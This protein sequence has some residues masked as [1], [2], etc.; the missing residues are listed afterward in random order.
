MGNELKCT[1][2]FGKETSEGKALLE[3][4]EILFRGD[5]RLKIPFASIK[6]A[7]AVDGELHLQTANG[8]A[9]FEL[10][11]AAEK[12]REK[13]LHPKSRI[14]K[15]GVKAGARVSM[16]GNFEAELFEEL[17]DLETIVTK[18]KVAADSDAVF[19][20]ADS[21]KE[22]SQVAKIAKSVKG[23]AAL[24]IVY[25][26]GQKGITENDVIAAGRKTGLKDVKVVGFSS[27]HTALKFVIPLDKR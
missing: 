14:E 15:L 12:W 7:K 22:L 25:P 1:V 8:L 5:F 9:V 16:V 27:T 21:Q 6:S 18:D 11:P 19:F 23:A 4:S 20:A 10:G 3:T 2:R 13:I 24:W 26:K 17:R